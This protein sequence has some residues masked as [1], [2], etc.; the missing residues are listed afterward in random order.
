MKKI[1]A[2]DYGILPG[3]KQNY[4]AD[5]SRL[6][7]NAG[8]G[9]EIV[10]EQ[11]TYLFEYENTVRRSYAISNTS[12]PDGQSV[13]IVLENLSNVTLDF[14]N[15]VLL[16]TG[17]Q[18]PF[19]IDECRGITLKNASLDWK[20]PT[21]AEG[22]VAEADH[23]H[24][25]LHINN[26]VF[27][28]FVKDGE[29]FFT[30]DCREE[31]PFWA[32]MEYDKE[33]LRV[34]RG[35][36]DTFP[37]V[38]VSEIDKN[39]VA[40]NA[41]FAVPPEKGNY[42]AL[43]FGKRDHAG[44]F[45]Q[46]SSDIRFENI[47]VFNSCGIAFVCQFCENVTMNGISVVPNE[48]RG[49]FVSSA[50]DDA[51]QFSNCKGQIKIENCRFRG[52]FDDSVNVHGT[53]TVITN[54]SGRTVR[55]EFRERDSAGFVRYARR[56]DIISFIDRRTMDSF[57]SAEVEEYRLTDNTHFEITFRTN[58][59]EAVHVNDAMENLTNTPDVHI[60]N[61][62]VGSA[63][64]RGILIS[65]PGKVFIENNVFDTSGSAILC[66]GDANG[67]FESGACRDV[68]ITGNIFTQHCLSSN[69]QFCEG[70]I[71][72]FPVIKEPQNSKGFHGNIRITNNHFTVSDR[73][74]LYALCVKGLVFSDNTV[75]S[76]DRSAG[77]RSYTKF[78]YCRDV[79]E[80]NNRYAECFPT[81][82]KK[83]VT[84]AF[85]GDSVTEGCFE[86]IRKE[87]GQIDIVRE[88][89]CAY[90]ILLKNKLE[91]ELPGLCVNTVNAGRSGDSSADGLAR[92][93]K[94]VV[95]AAPDT[96]V[97]CFGLND[98]CRRQPDEYAK[99]MDGIFTA[100]HEAE[101]PVIF[102]TPNRM[103]AYVHKEEFPE[104]VK[105]AEDCASCQNSGEMDVLI[106]LGMETAQKHGISVC[107]CYS[108]WNRMEEVG[109]DTTALLCNHIN[110]PSRQL[111]RLFAEML[112]PYVR[113][114]LNAAGDVRHSRDN[115]VLP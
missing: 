98:A 43:R 111:H 83:D 57:A 26:E 22:T 46:E 75:I 29:L 115:R 34:R 51:M 113:D 2:A 33:S 71:S 44:L 76:F 36:G 77:D 95:S 63:R 20:T 12:D 39:T 49:R 53:S 48:A 78:E 99:N 72:L 88:P 5:I 73:R 16:F 25:V 68:T 66:S 42:L 61:C 13:S 97:V 107:D 11:G 79:T 91:T 60:D 17:W 52:M 45:C 55:G 94:D 59:P 89:G 65:T 82:E 103:N 18:M 105:T 114:I 40:M 4:A 92:V 1:Y 8:D 81:A 14:Q 86:L 35:A 56:G 85:L 28:H 70:I 54:V 112:F 27:P 37:D 3:K 87:D 15:S 41:F 10:F 102:M 104:L 30:E 23:A 32:A 80:Q 110:H 58:V 93:M 62:F 31:L 19:A 50:H 108:V 69:Y 101:L 84:I 24:V 9:A 7:E 21:S 90:P 100:L 64:A 67:W 96:V 6:T 74:I 38:L 106:K 47:K 109:I